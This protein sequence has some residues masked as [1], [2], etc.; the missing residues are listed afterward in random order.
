[1]SFLTRASTP[2][3]EGVD[4]DSNVMYSIRRYFEVCDKRQKSKPM[5]FLA[6][7][8]GIKLVHTT[9]DERRVVRDLKIMS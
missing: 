8:I 4:S 5:N 2:G 7:I 3:R 9:I 6:N 1:M